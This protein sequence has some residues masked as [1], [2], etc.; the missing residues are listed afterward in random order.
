MKASP[1]SDDAALLVHLTQLVTGFRITQAI[2]VSAKLGIADRLP[3][4]P[5]PI[6][7]LADATGTHSPSLGRLLSSVGV[8]A[9]DADSRFRNTALSEPLKETHPRSMRGLALM[10]GSPWTWTP[11]GSL[12]ETVRT[13]QPAF[14]RTY[15][16][17]MFEYLAANPGDGAIFDQA[18][19][20]TSARDLA[21]ILDAYDFSRFDCIA[22][23][24]GGH[25]AFLQ[26][27]LSR[28]PGLRVILADQAS[29]VVNA[30]LMKGPLASRCT[31][32]PTDFLN[33]VP[34]GADCYVLKQVI[35]NW[36]EEDAVRILGNVR[37][38]MRPDGRLLLIG[39]VLKEANVPDPGR[40]LDIHML[41]MLPGRERTALEIAALL[42]QAGF[43]VVRVIPAGSAPSIV[44]AKP[45]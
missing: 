21:Q 22:D 11:W 3:A 4:G 10:Y 35:H 18:M 6:A 32:V 39:N 16:R 23:V 38:A 30:R 33:A 19:S 37:R 14:D 1:S 25:G 7:V 8:F 45:L 27:I 31:I 2:Y 36:G 5:Q 29:V 24:G 17:S 40:S 26:A 13:G 44:E 43:A 15:G 9:R 12:D 28:Y 20:S 34:A 42:D 41:V